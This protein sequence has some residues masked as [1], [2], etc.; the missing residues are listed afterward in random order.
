MVLRP[1]QLRC[2]LRLRRLRGNSLE[3]DLVIA[4][5]GAAA[6]IGI[7]TESTNTEITERVAGAHAEIP[8][9]T[10]RRTLRRIPRRTTRRTRR[11][12]RKKI[13]RENADTVQIQS[14]LRD[15]PWARKRKAKQSQEKF[16]D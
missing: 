2:K 6:K 12:I 9:K 13:L 8:R 16:S 4:D 10:L 3:A 11:R 5:I 7:T 1:L 14:P 15:R